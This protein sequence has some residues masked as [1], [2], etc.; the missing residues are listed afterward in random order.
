MK[1]DISEIK[2]QKILDHSTA[3]VRLKVC[4]SGD[5]T[6]SLPFTGEALREAA[7]SSLRGKP[8]VAKYNKWNKDFESHH[9]TL[10]IPLGYFIENQDFEY[11]EN[12]DG[13]LSLFGYAVLWKSYAPDQ[14]DVF[15]EKMAK[16]LPPTKPVSMEIYILDSKKGWGDDSTKTEVLKFSFKGVTILGDRY[17]PASP[18]SYAEMVTFSK[19]KKKEVEQYFTVNADKIKDSKPYL[20]KYY[21]EL[22]LPTESFEEKE[23]EQVI[24]DLNTEE[25]VVTETEAEVAEE[26]LETNSENFSEEEVSEDV[27]EEEKEE[28]VAVDFEAKYNELCEKYAE[29]EANYAKLK[30]D[31][32]AY[33]SEVEEL[34]EY[35]FAQQNAEKLSQIESTFATV[36]EFLPKEVI[37]EYREKVDSVEFAEVATFCNAI[38]ARVVDF[39]DFKDKNSENRMEIPDNTN[40][41]TKKPKFW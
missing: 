35:K 17:N 22:G 10:Q 30:D 7:E 21:S 13:T 11:V 34:K 33:M 18:G 9:P 20:L 28:E 1:F 12:E 5:N 19:E 15:V 38:K 16:G 36:S 27:A 32:S 26:V 40:P 23:G 3:L 14:Y 8:I 4:T 24:E 41:D 6:H 25:V 39:V 29:L 2:V 37:S 31:N